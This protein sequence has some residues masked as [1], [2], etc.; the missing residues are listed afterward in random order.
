MG[1]RSLISSGACIIT[2]AILAPSIGTGPR[3]QDLEGKSEVLSAA[4]KLMPYFAKEVSP[5]LMKEFA[6]IFIKAVESAQI[7]LPQIFR[8]LHA[9]HGAV[10]EVRLVRMSKPY[11]A[12]VEFLFENGMLVPTLIEVEAQPPHRITTLFFRGAQR[13]KEDWD[14]LRQELQRLPGKLSLWCRRLEPEPGVILDWN[15]EESLAVASVFKLL[16]LVAAVDEIA[17]GKRRWEDVVRVR[18]E[19]ASLPAGLLHDWPEGAPLTW[20]TLAA[21]MIG[22]SDNTAADHLMHLLGRE[23]VEQKQRELGV[24]RPERNIPFLTTAELFKLKLVLSAPQQEA[25]VTGDVATK[26]K[27]LDTEV[28]A[29]S[30]DRPRPLTEPQRV[31]EIEWFFSAADVGRIL[32]ALWQRS[33][34][35]PEVLDILSLNPGLPVNRRYWEYVGYK[36]GSEP[37]VLAYALLLRNRMGQWYVFAIVWN[38]PQE[39]LEPTQLH[40]LALRLLRYVEQSCP[41]RSE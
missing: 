39:P 38:H 36:G 17:K 7:D 32:E 34:K 30:L 40:T 15:S 4:K 22:Q 3:E 16:V 5:N 11:R 2:L 24:K 37:G 26:R 13:E 31:D 18:R 1:A 20:F 29:A 33:K 14:I 27:L 23:R 25:F 12:E 41:L 19:W 21:L 10:R 9:K 35:I 8:D 28:K 6:P